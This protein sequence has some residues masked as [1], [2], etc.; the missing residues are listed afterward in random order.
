MHSPSGWSFYPSCATV[1]STLFMTTAHVRSTLHNWI[2]LSTISVVNS[3]KDLSILSINYLN[4]GSQKD[5][6]SDPCW[7][8]FKKSINWLNMF[9][10]RLYNNTYPMKSLKMVTLLDINHCFNKNLNN[11]GIKIISMEWSIQKLVHKLNITTTMIPLIPLLKIK[12]RTF[13]PLMMSLLIIG[14][15]ICHQLDNLLQNILETV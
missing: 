14:T 8:Y 6:R 15:L 11:P 3:V 12:C 9:K 13:S 7:T 10:S 5:L 2:N 4:P 1:T